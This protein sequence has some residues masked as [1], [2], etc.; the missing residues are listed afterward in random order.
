MADGRAHH[1]S[2]NTFDKRGALT[3]TK[4]KLLQSSKI[5]ASQGDA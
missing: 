1:K 5:L 4:D 2:S 3:D